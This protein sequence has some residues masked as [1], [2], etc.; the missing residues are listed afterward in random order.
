MPCVDP[1]GCVQ[2]HSCL[3]AIMGSTFAAWIAGYKPKRIP[4]LM[5]IRSGRR[6]P[7]RVI[8]VIIPEKYVIRNGISAPGACWKDC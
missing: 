1:F 2:N 6:I 4:M 7:L 5:L 8:T 3:K